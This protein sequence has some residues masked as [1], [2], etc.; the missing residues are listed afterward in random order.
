VAILLL[1]GIFD[2][3]SGNAIHSVLLFTTGI[4]LSWDELLHGP[5]RAGDT[6][7]LRSPPAR[8][9]DRILTLTGGQGARSALLIAAALGYAIVVGGFARYSWPATTAVIIPGAAALAVAWREPLGQES[10]PEKLDPLGTLAWAAVFVALSL[11]ELISLLLQPSLTTDSYAHPTIS[12]LTDPVLAS[13]PGR[14]IV[15]VLWLAFG[16]FLLRQ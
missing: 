4:A 6:A 12:V 1:A 16:W 14:T 3:L 9:S 8:R 13:H 7:T 2:G 5:T 15:L 11:W 10:G